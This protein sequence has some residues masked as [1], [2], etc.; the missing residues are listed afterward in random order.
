MP[1]VSELEGL[2]LFD[3]GSRLVP[4]WQRPYLKLNQNRVSMTYQDW[5]ESEVNPSVV[6]TIFRTAI[7]NLATQHFAR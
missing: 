3:D 2:V 4:D 5:V 7:N 1:R 6:S